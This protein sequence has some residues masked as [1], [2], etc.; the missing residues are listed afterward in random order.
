M[1][2]NKPEAEKIFREREQGK[3]EKER[4]ER[5]EQQR[6]DDEDR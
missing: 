5:E 3:Q 6:L 1:V 4:L 2:D